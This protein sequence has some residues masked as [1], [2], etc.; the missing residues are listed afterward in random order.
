MKIG[1]LISLLFLIL[2][3]T[4]GFIVMQES[5]SGPTSATSAPGKLDRIVLDTSQL[6]RM[7]EVEEPNANATQDYNEAIDLY[8][9]NIN[10][11][12]DDIPPEDLATDLCKILMRG[13]K[14]G[15]VDPGFLD[16]RV[17]LE[18]GGA[19]EMREAV[20]ALASKAAT[21]GG[22]LQDKKTGLEICQAV[23]AFGER[24]ALNSEHI[25]LRL[26]GESAMRA[27]G[28]VMTKSNILDDTIPEESA[29]W[30]KIDNDWAP[31]LNALERARKEKL[32]I[33]KAGD[34]SIHIGDLL[35][36]AQYDQD[37]SFRVLAVQKLGVA[38]WN[39]GTQANDKAI[40][41]LLEKLKSDPNPSVAKAAGFAQAI[42]AK[43]IQ[44]IK[45]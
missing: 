23:W 11:F 20:A 6:P 8:L 1:I 42:K 35:W 12:R 28:N 25:D 14:K 7:W 27:A 3:V 34:P 29:I 45:W 9:D 33:V 13:A 2:I 36:I 24:V 16:E 10:A 32:E 44:T 22:T 40:K 18:P 39:P 4:A 5:P 15:R 37:P 43:E 38:Q 41:K 26:A 31:V 30:D 19:R 21:H 17:T